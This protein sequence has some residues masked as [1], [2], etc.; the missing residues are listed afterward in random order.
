MLSTSRPTLV[1]IFPFLG[2][3]D[4][5]KTV[6]HCLLLYQLLKVALKPAL[7]MSGA[8]LVEL[9]LV[10]CSNIVLYYK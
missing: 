5:R 8:K 10:I 4:I 6:A 7:A 9:W 3:Q 2:N 1:I